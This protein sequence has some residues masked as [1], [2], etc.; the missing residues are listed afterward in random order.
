MFE[1]S[2]LRHFLAVHRGGSLSAAARELRVNQTT[3]GRRLQQLEESLGTRLFDRMPNG[4]TL[5]PAGLELLPAAERVEGEALAVERSTKGR[6]RRPEG[7]V[8][9]TSTEVLG[10]RYLA[11]RLVGLRESFPGLRLEL[12]TAF[13]A[14]NLVRHEA[15]VAVR[16]MPTTHASLV[17]R[18]AGAYAN[19][20]YAARRYVERRG[21]PREMDEVPKHTLLG[22]DESLASTPETAWMERARAGTQLVLRSNSTNTL[23]AAARE[24]IGL[25]LLPCFAAD[26]DPELVRVLDGRPV[27]ERDIWLV[28]HHDLVRVPRVRAVTTYLGEIIARDQ[29]MLLGRR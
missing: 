5:T 4:F 10:S 25:A 13:R 8:R 18:R 16:I 12:L 7:L 27:L 9:V 3:V 11:P 1:W 21:A 17:V 26:M 2:D 14:L 15:D 6:D 19:A 29:A 24:G 28:V 20:L 22:F 23:M